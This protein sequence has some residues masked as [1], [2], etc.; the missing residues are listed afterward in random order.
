MSILMILAAS[1]AQADTIYLSKSDWTPARA[2]VELNQPIEVDTATETTSGGL[3]TLGQDT[4]DGAGLV[5]AISWSFTVEPIED[6]SKEAWLAVQDAD[7]FST[8]DA[9]FHD[10]TRRDGLSVLAEGDTLYGLIS[11]GDSSEFVVTAVIEEHNAVVGMDMGELIADSVYTVRAGAQLTKGAAKIATG[12]P[13]NVIEGS[14]DVIGA[15][16]SV[17]VAWTE[18]DTDAYGN[19]WGWDDVESYLAQLGTELLFELLAYVTE[20]E[21]EDA[22]DEEKERETDEFE[23]TLNQWLAEQAAKE[24]DEDTDDTQD[25]GAEAD[26]EESGCEEGSDCEESDDTSSEGEEEK[27]T[28]SG[29]AS[30]DPDLEGDADGE[31]MEQFL[32]VAGILGI[33][34]YNA[35]AMSDPLGLRP[36]LDS[37]ETVDS[38]F[39]EVVWMDYDCLSSTDLCLSG[40]KDDSAVYAELVLM[41]TFCEG[42]LCMGAAKGGEVTDTGLDKF[43]GT[44]MLTGLKANT[45]EV[46][47]DVTGE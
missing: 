42:G 18:D 43:G 40:D 21:E 10:A 11:R 24:K 30:G 34:P 29:A 15:F 7:A 31:V 35:D 28:S 45:L 1:T 13:W 20:E 39:L 44:D 12:T 26:A 2:V 4:E 25:V 22:L 3:V 41:D 47:V 37:G 23:A 33:D 9:F 19:I 32:V 14:V 8:V 6:V 16:V 36:G 5:T 17:V 38:A 27:D 46:F